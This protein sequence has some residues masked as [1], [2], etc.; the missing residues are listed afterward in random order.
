MSNNIW[1]PS[2]DEV[3]KINLE[4]SQLFSDENKPISPEGVRSL[5]MLSSAC[6]RPHTSYE[7]IEKYPCLYTKTAVLFHGIISNHPFFN[8]NKRTALM[9]A[10]STL[11]RNKLSINLGV[12]AVE[13]FDLTLGLAAN[14]FPQADHALTSDDVVNHLSAWFQKNATAIPEKY[15]PHSARFIPESLIV[16]FMPVLRMLA[17]T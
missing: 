16:R 6:A 15:E 14:R 12:T 4:I 8:G 13:L 3:L 17:D 7:G 1:M 5:H 11:Y 10:L 9:V 2:T